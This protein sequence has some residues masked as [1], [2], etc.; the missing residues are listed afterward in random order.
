MYKNIPF[1]K[2][3]PDMGKY[4]A[5]KAKRLR[6]NSSVVTSVETQ[7]KKLSIRTSERLKDGTISCKYT[8]TLY[9]Y[10]N[11]EKFGPDIR[12]LVFDS[13]G[14]LIGVNIGWDDTKCRYLLVEND[15]CI[16]EENVIKDF[17]GIEIM[18]IFCSLTLSDE[19]RK[20]CTSCKDYLNS[21]CNPWYHQTYLENFGRIPGSQEYLSW[22]LVEM[23]ETPNDYTRIIANQGIAVAPYV[24]ISEN[25]NANKL[26]KC[27]YENSDLKSWLNEVFLNTF[28]SEEERKIIKSINVPS[29][30]EIEK[31]FPEE[32]DRKVFPTKYAREN[33]AAVFKNSD[34]ALSC[35]YWLADTERK[36]GM[37]ATVVLANGKIYQSAYLAASNVC[38]RPVIEIVEKEK[39]R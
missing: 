37:S 21:P 17:C 2:Y 33:G 1:V 6:E 32:K 39:L 26:R 36:A 38:V 3:R 15:T 19:A 13:Y 20:H 24:N 14:I 27:S 28:F 16:L 10:I 5:E 22:D 7:M 9:Y 34:S 11:S 30:A 4:S 29:V 35:V 8:N 31:W 12:E 25:Q 23:P 18:D